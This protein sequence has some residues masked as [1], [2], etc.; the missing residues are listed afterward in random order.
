[1][2]LNDELSMIWSGYYL[3]D[4]TIVEMVAHFIGSK[5]SALDPIQ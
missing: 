1:M 2:V 3:N 4:K 5:L